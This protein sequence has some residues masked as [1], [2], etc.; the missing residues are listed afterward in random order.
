MLEVPH[1]GVSIPVRRRTT[2]TPY[3]SGCLSA[4][5]ATPLYGPFND[6]PWSSHRLVVDHAGTDGRLLELGCSSGFVTEH[7]VTNRNRVTGVDADERAAALAEALCEHVAVGDLETMALPETGGGYDAIV[8]GDVLEHLRDPHALL[9]RLAPLLRPGGRLVVSTPNIATWRV[10]LMLLAGR[11]RYTERGILDRTHT[12]FF[13]RATLVEA[14]EGVGL[15][16]TRVEGAV[17][18]P[19]RPAALRR[20]AHAVIAAWPSLLADQLVVVAQRP[21]L[22]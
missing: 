1:G 12:H 19:V 14:I 15:L 3:D 21:A 8:A 6:L 2:L 22:S 11:F 10:R 16:V 9:A 4:A 5:I 18:A 7:L 20:V 13:T 17:P